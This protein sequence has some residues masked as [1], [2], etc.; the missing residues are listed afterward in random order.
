MSFIEEMMRLELSLIGCFMS[1]SAPF[2]G[3]EWRETIEALQNGGLDMDSMISHYFSL[4]E[5]P[6]IFAR[7]GAH[8][9]VHRKIIL[10][11]EGFT[12]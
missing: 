1:Y 5:T 4:A 9:L 12:Q 2:P 3:H 10:R 7:I 8:S 11:P 6:E